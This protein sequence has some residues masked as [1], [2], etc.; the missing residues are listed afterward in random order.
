MGVDGLHNHRK[1][2]EMEMLEKLENVIKRKPEIDILNE[3]VQETRAERL[4]Y[5]EIRDIIQTGAYDRSNVDSWKRWEKFGKIRKLNAL[6]K[7]RIR[8]LNR[9]NWAAMAPVAEDESETGSE[10][11]TSV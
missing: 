10:A 1:L 4:A 8:D 11:E 2:T 7:N 3:I 9:T 5:E 6:S